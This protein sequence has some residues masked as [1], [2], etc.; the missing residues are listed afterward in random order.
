[1]TLL[2]EAEI[3]RFQ[4][5]GA[6]VVRGAFTDWLDTMA[7]GIATNM[8]DP[9]PYASENKVTKGRFF[10]DYC[11][12]T[13]IPAFEKVIRHSPAARLAAEAMQSPIARIF[14]DHVLV[15]EPGTPKPTPWHQDAPYY[16][17]E[18]SQTV[19]LW[20]P[21]DP[22]R[23]ASLRLIAGSHR[24]PRMVRPVSWADDSDFYRGRQDWTPVPDPD[25]DPGD[26]TILE[27]PMEPG[28]AVLFDFRT[29]HGARGNLATTRRR[30]L[31]L[32][33]VGQ[34]ARYVER[35]GRTSPPFPGHGMQPGD[36]LRDDWFPIVWRG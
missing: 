5:D 29:V 2:T 10:D 30:A 20:I 27:W 24:W 23:E 6:L 11:N 16:F 32:R 19:S 33:F 15:K 17:V 31:S 25:T 8:A 14:H 34:D 12:W 18:G 4:Q 7:E 26:L 3:A 1:M 35:P 36:S 13:R 9:G 21:L 22:V 28:D